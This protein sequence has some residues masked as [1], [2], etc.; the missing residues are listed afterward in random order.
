MGREAHHGREEEQRRKAIAEL[1][2]ECGGRVTPV[3]ASTLPRDSLAVGAEQPR[4]DHPGDRQFLAL[5][6]EAQF[7]LAAADEPRKVT[8]K[9]N[10][11]LAAAPGSPTVGKM[12]ATEP[13]GAMV[14]EE[15]LQLREVKPAKKLALRSPSKVMGD[16]KALGGARRPVER[17]ISWDDSAG[18]RLLV[19]NWAG[20]VKVGGGAFH[21]QKNA[22]DASGKKGE[23]RKPCAP[24]RRAGPRRR[25]QPPATRWTRLAP[26][27]PRDGRVVDE[28]V[29]HR[30]PMSRRWSRSGA[31]ARARSQTPRRRCRPPPPPRG[32]GRRVE[33][34]RREEPRGEPPRSCSA[35]RRAR[36]RTRQCR[37]ALHGRE[38]RASTTEDPP[39]SRGPKSVHGAPPARSSPARVHRSAKARRG[40]RRARERAASASPRARRAP[41]GSRRCS[42]ARRAE[43]LDLGEPRLRRR[44]ALVAVDRAPAL[45]RV[46]GAA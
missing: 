29:V 21:V 11:M 16:P 20:D 9:F 37:G 35:S 44:D 10:N 15:E 46:D 42:P 5:E 26:P 8:L 14:V 2:G 23:R 41:R 27:P 39:A 31:R 36:P 1:R 7:T 13:G 34:E 24:R 17:H 4:H 6:P 43:R 3:T 12:V 33:L 19:K 32:A 40:A 22:Y 28:H 18:G 30:P 38:P 45:R 25:R